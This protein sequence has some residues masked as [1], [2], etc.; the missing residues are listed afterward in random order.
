MP[1]KAVFQL[2]EIDKTGL[3]DRIFEVL[4]QSMDERGYLFVC[5]RD[6]NVT[7]WSP[8][9]VEYFHMPG[10]YMYD[11]DSFWEKRIHPDDLTEYK[12]KLEHVL[13]GRREW[14]YFEYRIQN[15]DAFAFG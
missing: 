3:E 11:V 4:S 5:N 2:M 1:G 12:R 10:D 15:G 6:A 13:S 7:R 14:E 9:A 8:N